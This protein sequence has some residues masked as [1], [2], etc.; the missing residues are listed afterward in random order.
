VLRPRYVKINADC[1]VFTELVGISTDTL[2]EC[3]QTFPLVQRRLRAMARHIDPESMNVTTI[4]AN[5]DHLDHDSKPAES[6]TWTRSERE[7][8]ENRQVRVLRW[9][10]F[11]ERILRIDCKKDTSLRLV[12]RVVQFSHSTFGINDSH[13][14]GD[15]QHEYGEHEM[16]LDAAELSDNEL[17]SP[18]NTPRNPSGRFNSARSLHNRSSRSISPRKMLIHREHASDRPEGMPTLK[19]GLVEEL[20]NGMS[21]EERLEVALDAARH[22]LDPDALSANHSKT[23]DADK[24]G[25]V[26]KEG[27]ASLASPLQGVQDRGN[28]RSMS[29]LVAHEARET[30]LG[31][32]EGEANGD[33]SSKVSRIDRRLNKLDKRLSELQRSTDNVLWVLAKQRLQEVRERRQERQSRRRSRRGASPER[34]SEAESSPDASPHR[35]VR[36]SI[37]NGVSSNQRA[38]GRGSAQRR[39]VPDA[40]GR[41]TETATAALYDAEQW[42][43]HDGH[44][45]RAPSPPPSRSLRSAPSALRDR[46]HQDSGLSRPL[47]GHMVEYEGLH[48]VHRR[49]DPWQLGHARNNVAGIMTGQAAGRE[50]TLGR[51]HLFVLLLR[52][53]TLGRYHAVA[54]S[55][56]LAAISA[57]C[58]FNRSPISR[59][60]SAHTGRTRG[61][62]TVAAARG[63]RPTPPI[64]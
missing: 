9:G 26:Y 37:P 43:S 24:A 2:E 6:R 33:L 41:I 20:E 46:A 1:L 47:G 23:S 54:S 4:K 14:S 17:K 10:A 32:T 55:F 13:S 15:D 28:G 58:A 29:P 39:V 3:S 59:V 64:G 57:C 36:R 49:A 11:A 16:R 19:L 48:Q 34:K 45:F 21:E 5:W 63:P 8:E 38:S 42:R 52:E 27:D 25:D 62:S 31:A 35:P 44:R 22:R 61:C 53:L 60:A 18:A 40:A 56:H 30:T 7:E 50:L 12:N 51:Y